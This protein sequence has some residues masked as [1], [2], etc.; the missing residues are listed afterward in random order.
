MV[1]LLF[2]GQYTPAR[3][4][5]VAIM[6]DIH[7]DKTGKRQVTAMI[8]GTV[9]ERNPE[10]YIGGFSIQLVILLIFLQQQCT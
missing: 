1:N 8:S 9:D 3:I 6:S 2:E 10:V 4:R 5:E 7:S